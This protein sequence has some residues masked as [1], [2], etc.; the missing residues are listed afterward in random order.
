MKAFFAFFFGV[1]ICFSS[2]ANFTNKNQEGTS[3]M[4]LCMGM[5]EIAMEAFEMKNNKKKLIYKKTD[6]L[7]IAILIKK[8]MDV[9]YKAKTKEEAASKGFEACAESKIWN[10]ISN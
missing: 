5:S 10:E 2:N 4:L 9:G 3:K 7:L 1:L 8:S 6:D